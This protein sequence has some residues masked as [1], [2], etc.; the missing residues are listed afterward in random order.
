MSA[1]TPL[2]ALTSLPPVRSVRE[3]DRR[4]QIDRQRMIIES[5][6]TAG[7]DVRSFN[8]TSEISEL[9]KI[10]EGVTFVPV[11]STTEHLF[12][13]P[14]VPIHVMCRWATAAEAS[15]LILNADIELHVSS[16]ELEQVRQTS[17]AGLCYFIRYNHDGDRSRAA[18]D[19]WGLDAFLFHGRHAAVIPD[20]FLSMGQ[21]WWDY[22]LP[23]V[24][25]K[26]GLPLWGVEFPA[27]FHHNHA[28]N[29]SWDNW[30]RCAYEFDR[31]VGKLGSDRSS[32]A[33]HAMGSWAR[34]EISRM[35]TRIDADPRRM[36]QVSGDRPSPGIRSLLG[37]ALGCS[38]MNSNW[39]DRKWICSTSADGWNCPEQF[40]TREQAISYAINTLAVEQKLEQG[41]RVYTGELR[42]LEGEKLAE[43]AFD[44]QSA[45]GTIERWLRDHF[46]RDFDCALPSTAAQEADLRRR[47]IQT[48]GGWFRDHG[49]KPSAL[50]VQ[51]VR[52]HIWVVE[53]GVRVHKDQ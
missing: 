34:S 40:D 48:L 42:L 19:A 52:S 24:F 6:H 17:G 23:L 3:R 36:V 14:Y 43:H 38:V 49:I 31:F 46:G 37:A 5:W 20:S 7:L 47:L 28:L 16:S 39:T 50:T 22:W 15:V 11:E 13:K 27:I 12:G 2:F 9:A 1:S 30:Y 35:G 45:L 10:Y 26:K 33:C 21:P 51:H 41:R 8:A 32:D 53:N 25:V 29:W 44:E 4:A 18:P